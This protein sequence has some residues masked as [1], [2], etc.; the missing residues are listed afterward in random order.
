MCCA[1]NNGFNP[2]VNVVQ[3]LKK[4]IHH[5]ENQCEEN[6]QTYV[7]RHCEKSTQSCAMLLWC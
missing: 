3:N 2:D 5:L 1:C 6:V 4:V 7:S